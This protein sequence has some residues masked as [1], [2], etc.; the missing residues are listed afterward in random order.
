MRAFETVIGAFA[1][2]IVLSWRSC[3]FHVYF[4]LNAAM[5]APPVL[6]VQPPFEFDAPSTSGIGSRT[7]PTF[8][9]RPSALVSSKDYLVD[10]PLLTPFIK[11][12]HPQV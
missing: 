10:A 2:K 9:R 8:L 6:E 1:V 7:R 5:E 3:N 11:K 12:E 4:P